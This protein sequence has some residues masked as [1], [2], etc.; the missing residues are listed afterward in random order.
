MNQS[1]PICPLC[2]TLQVPEYLFLFS[3]EGQDLPPM[4]RPLIISSAEEMA[5]LKRL[6]TIFFQSKIK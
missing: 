4:Q 6:L 3:V 2:K 5:L 1:V